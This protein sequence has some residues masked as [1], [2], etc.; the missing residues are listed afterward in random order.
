MKTEIS[1]GDIQ[2]CLELLEYSRMHIRDAQ[3]TPDKVRKETP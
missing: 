1:L 3:G 2:V